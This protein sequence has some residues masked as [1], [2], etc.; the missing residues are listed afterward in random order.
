MEGLRLGLPWTPG[1]THPSPA[2]SQQRRQQRQRR[3]WL[4][5][6][7]GP[8]G[9][10]LAS[11]AASH[12]NSSSCRV[13]GERRASWT[14]RPHARP[15]SPPHAPTSTPPAFQAPPPGCTLG[16]GAGEGPPREGCVGREGC[17]GEAGARR[18]EVPAPARL[19]GSGPHP[20]PPPEPPALCSQFPCRRGAL[21]SPWHP[22][23]SLASGPHLSV[24]TPPTPGPGAPTPAP[25]VT[26][27]EG[28]GCGSPDAVGGWLC[29]ERGDGGGG[30]GGGRGWRGCGAG[31]L[32]CQG[33][34]THLQPGLS[35]AGNSGSVGDGCAVLE[36]PAG[37]CWRLLQ[38][39][40]P[41]R[42]R[43]E[44][45]ACARHRGHR[46]PAPGP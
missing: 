21:Q 20:I 40:T 1:S 25:R 46:G 6:P 22:I 36:A 38:P 9:E 30:P 19:P 3:R 32:G 2:W 10:I 45:E 27:R 26:L 13:W 18:E 12:P 16:R 35:S 5:G 44:A 17:Q 42:A 14:L 34:L 4:R 33:Q 15:T 23:V 7:R 11:A 41:S 28:V 31:S 39:L 43:A 29:R 37:R 8:S 24:S